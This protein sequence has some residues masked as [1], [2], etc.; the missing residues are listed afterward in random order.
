MSGPLARFAWYGDDFT[1]ATDTL[2]TFAQGGL[3]AILFLDVPTPAQLTRVGRLDAI[4]IAGA[5]RAMDRPAM[6]KA[7]APV[8]EFFATSGVR[9][10]HYKCCSTFDSAPHVGNIV[11]AV[12]T[13]RRYFPNPLVPVI[14]GQPSLGRYCLFSNLFASAGACSSVVRLD[15]HPTMAM[16]P[17]TPM[18]EADLRR[19]FA[20]LGWSRVAALHYPAYDSDHAVLD[21]LPARALADAPDAVLMDVGHD[22][23]LAPLGRLMWAQAE[24]QPLVAVGPSSVAQALVP[25]WKRSAS[26]I[27]PAKGPV[28]V[29]VGSL[30]PV[31]R[32]QMAASP[33]FDMIEAD[34]AR[35][36]ADASL[37]AQIL[38]DALGRLRAGRN[39]ILA[40]SDAGERIAHA[41]V[42]DATAQLTVQVVRQFPLKRLGIAG[43][44]TSSQAVKALG[45]WGLTYLAA[46][47]PGVALCRA[48]SDDCALDGLELMLKGGQMGPPDL[49]E[50]LVHG[51]K[52]GLAALA[53]C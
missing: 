19:H 50:Q 30:S 2:A 52:G 48:H 7:L 51:S 10:L 38:A 28:F 42:A 31:T 47:A 27:E 49:F 41:K 24:R 36:V 45:P 20:A 22:D 44:D 33:S 4:G 5:S 23:H 39:V 29:M 14:G 13:L 26:R 18:T 40:T 25:Q 53:G 35:L 12:D 46:L 16:H 34:A 15:R 11:V 6:E 37:G 8:G 17:V 43:G 3:R 21:A 9:I 32:Q 1:G